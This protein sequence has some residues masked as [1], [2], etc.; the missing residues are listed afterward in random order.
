MEKETRHQRAQM[1]FKD[2]YF[3]KSDVHVT[4]LGVLLNTDTNSDFRAGSEIRHV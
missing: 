2:Q 1:V 4:C 3:S